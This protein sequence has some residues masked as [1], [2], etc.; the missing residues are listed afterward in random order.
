MALL[1]QGAPPGIPQVGNRRVP[2]D[3]ILPMNA[4]TVLA[5]L[6]L[7]ITLI[8]AL[9]AASRMRA[10]VV[11]AVAQDGTATPVWTDIE[12][13]HY[14]QRDHFMAGINRLSA[15]FDEQIRTLKAK[16]ATMTTDTKDW[17]LAFKEVE[18][19]RSYLTSMISDLTKMTTPETWSDQK[20]KVGDA[21]KRSQLAVDAMNK[22]VTS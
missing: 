15:R 3:T 13:D 14:E 17:D 12:G 7:G 5:R 6:A 21:W 11:T 9:G 20:D 4:N 10:D 8:S 22:T 1:H 2:A 19:S 18:D 16:R